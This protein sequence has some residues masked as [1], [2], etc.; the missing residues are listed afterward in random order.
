MNHSTAVPDGCRSPLDPTAEVE[1]RRS[2]PVPD[3]VAGWRTSFGI[4]VAGE[5]DG[6]ATIHLCSCKRSGLGFFW[7]MTAGSPRLY[8]ELESRPWY[9]R[10]GQW[11]YNH[12]ISLVPAGAQL[13]DLGC[14]AGLFVEQC[15]SLGHAAEGIDFNPA[16]VARAQTA[17]LPV[18]CGDWEQLAAEKPNAYG[19]VTAFQ[20]L[21]HL[22]DPLPFLR[23]A[24]RLLRPGG[25]LLLAVPDSDGWL[26][27][28][29]NLLDMPAHHVLHWNPEAM[30]FLT[31]LFPL[32]L[33]ELA[34]EP[35]DPDHVGDY[36]RAR[37]SPVTKPGARSGLCARALIRT[38]A[39]VV[40]IP[41]VRKRCSGQSMVA[42][43]RR[44]EG[45][46]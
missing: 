19:M 2:I 16:A 34:I 5:F 45:L 10:R 32:E 15:R 13:L 29:G 30:R 1:I 11:E 28:T 35:L 8:A 40:S 24:V 43:F 12:A 17:G 18:R 25:R 9:Y 26:A 39:T 6:A 46:A 44:L 42:V 31:R 4:D 14:G 38:C 27:R 7:P 22:S 3:L 36:V 33:E 41:V 21:E 20:L 23:S 37:I